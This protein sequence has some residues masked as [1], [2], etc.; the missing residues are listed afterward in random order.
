MIP[1]MFLDLIGYLKTLVRWLCIWATVSIFIMGGIASHAW[2]K[3]A[4][5]GYDWAFK[6]MKAE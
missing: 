3:T 4:S 1:P 2:I 6:V 5:N